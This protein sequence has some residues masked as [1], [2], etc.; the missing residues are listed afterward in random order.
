MSE[1]VLPGDFLDERK[2]RKVGKGAYFEGEKVFAKVLGVARVDQDF[3]SVFPLSGEYLPS[4]GDRA[5]GTIEEVQISGWLVNINSPYMAFLPVSEGVEE[6]FD[7][8]QT[9]ISRFY[10]KGDIISCR[11]SKVTKAKTVQVTMN[12]EGARK[13]F[14]GIILKV[15]PSKVPRMIGKE[16]S[17]VSL[18]KSKTGCD[19]SIGQNG[20]VWIRGENKAKAIEAILTIEKES[21]VAGL[22]EKIEKLLG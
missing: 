12:D 1:I 21:H 16:G 10:D 15:T 19:I 3:I 9:D 18:I 13:L 8:R 20:V 4:V 2:G 22:T 7:M 11:V 5:I 14:G 17:M 6:F